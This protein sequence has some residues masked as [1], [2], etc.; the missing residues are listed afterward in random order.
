[1]NCLGSITLDVVLGFRFRGGGPPGIGVG[2]GFGVDTKIPDVEVHAF[3]ARCSFLA[4][5]FDEDIF[6]G[7]QTVG[8]GEF[9]PASADAGDGGFDQVLLLDD[10][11]GDLALHVAQDAFAAFYLGAY[12]AE[13]VQ[14]HDRLL[15]VLR[16]LRFLGTWRGAGGTFRGGRVGVVGGGVH[17]D[18][19]RR[20][21]DV[22]L[23]RRGGALEFD[24]LLEAG[25]GLEG[26]TENVGFGVAVDVAGGLLNF[27]N[28][29]LALKTVE[30]E[31]S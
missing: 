31:Y 5:H 18:V 2:G 29:G 9:K 7:R 16:L 10:F 13:T 6:S 26:A 12:D 4:H 22:R 14:G 8:R 20:N 17:V 21:I 15:Q 23:H 3:F 24:D 1:M 28:L 30:Q 27:Y 11:A 25:H 19:E